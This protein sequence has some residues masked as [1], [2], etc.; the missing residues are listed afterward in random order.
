MKPIAK[1]VKI[2]P[3]LK[4]RSPYADCNPLW[5]VI[6]KIGARAYLCEIVNEGVKIGNTI[7]PSE[8]AGI[9]KAFLTG[10]ITSSLS[11]EEMFDGLMGDHNRFYAGLHNGQIIHYHDGHNKWIRC[12]AQ[13]DAKDRRMKLQSIALLGQWHDLPSRNRDGSINYPYHVKKIMEKELFE[14]NYSN[15]YEAFQDKFNDDPR[16]MNAVSIYVPEMTPDESVAASLW[17]AIDKIRSLSNGHE[18]PAII[19]KEIKKALQSQ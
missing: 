4:F 15:L 3:D 6:S 10:E 1:I 7:Y 12:E 19:L 16:K 17:V 5:K 8:F 9:R 14:P 11:M 13:L 18:N 2:K